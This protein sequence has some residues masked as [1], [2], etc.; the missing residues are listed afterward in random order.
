MS[1]REELA[2][3]IAH[4][5]EAQEE[6][7]RGGYCRIDGLDDACLDGYFNLLDVADAVLGHLAAQAPLMA[8]VDEL[9]AIR[10]EREADF[11]ADVKLAAERFQPSVAH[12]IKLAQDTERRHP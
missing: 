9:T 8:Q 11:L 2:Y 10:V 3:A 5:L 4:E 6:S 12:V 1:A 7:D